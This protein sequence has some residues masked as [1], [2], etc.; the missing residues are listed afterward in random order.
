MTVDIPY[1]K[2][3]PKQAQDIAKAMA[4]NDAK[5]LEDVL[6]RIGGIDENAFQAVLNPAEGARSLI[7]DKQTSPGLFARSLARSPDQ[8]FDWLVGSIATKNDWCWA[9]TIEFGAARDPRTTRKIFEAHQ[10]VGS[11]VIL[12]A[13]VGW[14][15][16]FRDGERREQGQ[17]QTDKWSAQRAEVDKLC[18]DFLEHLGADT[19][20]TLRQ[21][22]SVKPW[23]KPKQGGAVD[24][25]LIALERQEL[26]DAAPTAPPI[27]DGTPAAAAAP[28][29]HA[30]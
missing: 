4:R 20:A 2:L 5:R 28:R 12:G 7:S 3:H 30:L 10:R 21:K 16:D 26:T 1:K 8:I 24:Q 14:I 23:T 29:R 11:D 6:T 19:L 17:A 25:A 9:R 22:L 18:A 13:M 27:K 15:D